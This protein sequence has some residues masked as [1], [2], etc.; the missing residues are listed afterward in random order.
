MLAENLIHLRRDGTLDITTA[1]EGAHTNT[2]PMN[3]SLSP[4]PTLQTFSQALEVIAKRNDNRPLPIRTLQEIGEASMKA[5]KILA[6]LINNRKEAIAHHG[7]ADYLGHER[8]CEPLAEAWR[9]IEA[10]DNRNPMKVTLLQLLANKGTPATLQHAGC[11]SETGAA[12]DSLVRAAASSKNIAAQASKQILEAAENP[13]I[14]P[15]TRAMA[16]CLLA[17]ARQPVKNLEEIFARAHK[18]EEVLKALAEGNNLGTLLNSPLDQYRKFTLMHQI[19]GAA[20]VTNL[21]GPI[22]SSLSHQ[23]SA[24][25]GVDREFAARFWQSVT[26]AE[27]VSRIARGIA[28]RA[29]LTIAHSEKDS[30]QALVAVVNE[31][32]MQKLER[33]RA[34]FKADSKGDLLVM[35]C[36]HSLVL[37]IFEARE[38]LDSGVLRELNQTL[39]ALRRHPDPAVRDALPNIEI[40]LPFETRSLASSLIRNFVDEL[41][42]GWQAIV[43]LFEQPYSR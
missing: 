18:D 31:D 14:S 6:Y 32:L 28:T 37:P 36:I 40:T 34:L 41:H 4:N 26:Q 21:E 29:L 19:C 11:F 24:L 42:I 13:A 8:E 10:L 3:A 5:Q 22:L 38:K 9:Q 20:K 1:K 17:D 27:P 2:I 16:L 30:N 15:T 33:A 25:V 7:R 35:N 39:A 12:I 43:R 23:S